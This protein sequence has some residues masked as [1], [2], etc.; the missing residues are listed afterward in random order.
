MGMKIWD[1]VFW[2]LQSYVIKDCH[3]ACIGGHAI[4]NY[5]KRCVVFEQL[6]DEVVLLR[7]LAA[8]QPVLVS[9]VGLFWRRVLNINGE[10]NFF[11]KNKKLGWVTCR[12]MH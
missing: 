10:V 12:F 6:E 9:L 1:S 2:E 3:M 4:Q 11:A 7:E 8:C 5:T